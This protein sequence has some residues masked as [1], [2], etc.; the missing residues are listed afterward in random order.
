M[1]IIGLHT[2]FAILYSV[3][4]IT[5]LIGTGF[6]VGFFSQLK[7]MFKP[8]RVV[9]TAILIGSLVMVW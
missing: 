2:I 4:I 6:L 5:S 3:G 8:V 1:L 9:A 7:A